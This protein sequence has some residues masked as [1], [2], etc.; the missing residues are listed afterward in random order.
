MSSTAPMGLTAN[1]EDYLEAIMDLESQQKVARVK[2]IASR[3]D[4]KTPSVSGALK[5]LKAR[6]LVNHEAYGYVTLTPRG[7]ELA[8]QVH[9]RHL[10]IVDFLTSIMRLPPR[11]A[12]PEACGLEH[13][14]SGPGLERLVALTAFMHAHPGT[15]QEWLEHLD[16]VDGQGDGER[17]PADDHIP[18]ADMVAGADLTLDQ[19]Q[20]GVT[21]RITSVGGGGAIRRRLL[22]MGLQPG[23]EVRVAR[24]APLGDPVE[25]HLMEYHLSLRKMEAAGIGVEIV[26][27]PLSLVPAGTTV[28]LDDVLGCGLLEHLRH[29]GLVL[30]EPVTVV[31]NLGATGGMTVRV[32]GLDLS[33]GRGQ[34]QR[35]MVRPQGEA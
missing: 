28:A 31:S 7:R 30:G 14:L 34:A 27:M 12:E 20:P 8:R 32:Q 11:Q 26:A 18:A 17:T 1:M 29:E 16:Q 33:L 9:D 13:A 2:D 23:V 4:V 10:A 25:V 15:Y 21:V 6:R 24:V 19:V 22:D 35:F 3:L 5:A